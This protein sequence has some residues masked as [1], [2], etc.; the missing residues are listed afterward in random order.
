VPPFCVCCAHRDGDLCARCGSTV[1]GQ[2]G[3]KIRNEAFVL[4]RQLPKSMSQQLTPQQKLE[5]GEQDSAT[6]GHD[7]LRPLPEHVFRTHPTTRAEQLTALNAPTESNT[8]APCRTESPMP[9]TS[10]AMWAVPR[11]GRTS[12]LLTSAQQTQLV[13]TRSLATSAP[14]IQRN[15]RTSTPR[16]RTHEGKPSARLASN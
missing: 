8:P 14:S 15:D 16:S 11:G 4:A 3:Q 6:P 1:D 7:W 10:R 13:N 9:M 2:V 5:C 12:P